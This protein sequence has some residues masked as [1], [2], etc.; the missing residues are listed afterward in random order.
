MIGIY[1]IKCLR[2]KRV[3]IGSSINIE[4]RIAHHKNALKRN[5]HSNSHL[6]NAWNKYGEENFKFSVIEICNKETILERENFYIEKNGSLK[7]NKGFNL[8]VAERK[9]NLYCN[10][11]YL[12]KLSL[13]KKGKTPSNITLCR[14]KQKRKILEYENGI[15]VREYNSTKEAGAFLNIN[16]KLI[17]NILRRKVKKTKLFPNKIWKY[18][19]GQ[20][21]RKIK[22]VNIGWSKGVYKKVYQ[23]DYNH[24]LI[25]AFDSIDDVCFYLNISRNTVINSCNGKTKKCIKLKCVFKYE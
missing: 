20:P 24:N 22:T 16:Y 1:C 11:E 7:T 18:K 8:I 9:D 15:F 17:N 4:Y 19:D 14:E 10:N 5:D 2:N 23:Y 25:R 12:T 13:I 6:Q 3:Y 21:T